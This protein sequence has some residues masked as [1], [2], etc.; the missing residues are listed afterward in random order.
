[1]ET[2]GLYTSINIYLR[3]QILPAMD[4]LILDCFLVHEK[5]ADVGPDTNFSS[6]LLPVHVSALV[7]YCHRCD[8][9]YAKA[10][11]IG[12]LKVNTNFPYGALTNGVD[13]FHN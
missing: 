4:V 12:K 7:H 11:R 10:Q 1:M 6:Q 2:H 3:S 8:C 13:A 9:V 5:N